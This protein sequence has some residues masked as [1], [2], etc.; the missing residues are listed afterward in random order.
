MLSFP[1][2]AVEG[3]YSTSEETEVS[4]RRS[5]APR[6][7]IDSSPSIVSKTRSLLRTAVGK[8]AAAAVGVI[9]VG[10]SVSGLIVANG[11]ASNAFAMGQPTPAVESFDQLAAQRDQV[12]AAKGDAIDEAGTQAAIQSRDKVLNSDASAIKT[13]ADRLKNLAEFFWPTDGKVVSTFGERY[14]PILHYTRLHDGVDIHASCGQNVYAAQSG[15]V[16]TAEMGYNGGEG[17]NVHLNNGDINGAQIETGY[18]HLTDYVV[19]VGDHVDKGQLL[20]HVGTTG[21]ST[22]CHLHFMLH[23]D[24]QPTNP[25]EYAQPPSGDAPDASASKSS[26]QQS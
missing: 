24:G 16:I 7:G 8:A 14:H 23:K 25:L 19:K 11:S 6:R 5:S 26:S 12:L 2:V 20:G 22:G 17:N 1:L 10:G 4:D 3:R 15:T 9:V 18:L 21:L 13:E